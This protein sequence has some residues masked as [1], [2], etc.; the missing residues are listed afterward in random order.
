M[1]SWLNF[2]ED[3]QKRTILRCWNRDRMAVE[4]P[5]WVLIELLMALCRYVGTMD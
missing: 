5:S 1:Q 2:L 3:L 4:K